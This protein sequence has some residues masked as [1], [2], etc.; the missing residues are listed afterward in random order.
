MRERS[1]TWYEDERSRI[2]YTCE[3]KYDGSMVAFVIDLESQLIGL[4]LERD[5]LMADLKSGVES[6]NSCKHL[7]TMEF[8]CY[9]EEFNCSMCRYTEECKCL[10][11]TSENNNWEWRGM[12]DEKG[13]DQ[14]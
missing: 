11:C 10:G 8:Q 1:S 3:E 6:C 4:K 14:A 5:Q 12:P 13:R 2:L 7:K 9:D